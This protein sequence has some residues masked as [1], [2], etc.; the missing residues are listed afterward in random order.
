MAGKAYANRKRVEDRPEADFYRT[1]ES[2]T[3]ALIHCNFLDPYDP[4]HEVAEGDGAITSVL[5]NAGFK[6]Y[7]D[8]IRTSELDFLTDNRL[9]KQICTNPPFSLFDEFVMHAQDVCTD[10]FVMLA[11]M[12]FF[13]AYNRNA[14]GVWNHLR[15]VYIFNRQVDYRTPRGKDGHFHVGN[16]V[17]GWFCWD[18]KWNKKHWNTSIIDVQPYATLGAYKE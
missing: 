1:P 18:M 15:H 16:L 10:R 9:K 2:L 12:N 7:A 13:G 17:T 6:V 8:D 5:R 14:M 11:K 4:V 3:Q